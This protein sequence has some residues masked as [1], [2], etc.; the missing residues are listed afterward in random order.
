MHYQPRDR[1]PIMDFGF[2]DETRVIWREYGLP[3]DVNTDDFFGMDPLWIGISGNPFLCPAFESRVLEDHPDRQVSIDGDGVTKESGK[4]L[5][6]IPHYL[7]HTLKDRESW[8]KEVKWRLDPTNPDRIPK[9][10]DETAARFKAPNRDYPIVI[11]AGSIF[12]RLRDL[13]GVE[14]IAMLVYDDRKLFEEMVERTTDCVIA[15]ITP[16]LETGIQFEYASMWEDMC[17]RAGPL[18]TPRIFHQVLVPNYQ[19]IT[20]TLRRY[21]VD[22]VVL[23]CDGDISLL[24]PHWLEGGVNCMFPI[25]VGVWGADPV[26][27]RKQ[28][29]KGLLMMGGVSKRLLAGTHEEI[30]AEVERLAPLVDEGGFI[31]TPDHRVPPDVPLTSYI[32]YLQEARRVWGRNLP[33]LRPMGDLDLSAPRARDSE[34][35]WDD[36]G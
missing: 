35:R 5:G 18:L 31:P 26:A 23:D 27:Y 14:G 15:A 13:M 16:I 25:E 33:N 28:Y 11:G 2:W 6:T 36:V 8:E 10:L 3:A 22:V 7:D 12:G 9:D 24:V 34:Y 19:R 1:C 29:G 32:H 20:S 4:F 17:Y 30:T 21:G